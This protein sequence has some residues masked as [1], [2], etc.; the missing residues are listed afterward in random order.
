MPNMSISEQELRVVLEG[1]DCSSECQYSLWNELQNGYLDFVVNQL[2]NNKIV[3]TLPNAIRYLIDYQTKNSITPKVN[4]SDYEKTSNNKRSYKKI[5]SILEKKLE[6]LSKKDL[7]REFGVRGH[8]TI[9]KL[10]SGEIVRLERSSKKINQPNLQINLNFG[11]DLFFEDIKK[12]PNKRDGKF[13][14]GDYF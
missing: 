11:D 10:F 5:D 6:S 9:P 2:I 7:T 3:D 12:E 4:V 14:I 8:V 1:I 13:F